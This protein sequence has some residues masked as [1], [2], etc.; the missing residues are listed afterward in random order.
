MTS[1]VGEYLRKTREERKLSLEQ[2]AAVTRVRLSY[3]IAIENDEQNDLPSVVQARGF[4]RLY[5]SFLNIPVQP[6]LDGWKSGHF[7]PE[8]LESANSQPT[9]APVPLNEITNPAIARPETEV[10]PAPPSPSPQEPRPSEI[11][12]PAVEA[13]E[14]QEWRKIFQ[15]I[16]STL[17]ERREKLSLSVGDI[18]RFTRLKGYYIQ[19]LEDGRVEDLPSMVQGRGMLS[20]Y[21][22]F[23]DLDSEGLM[24]RFADALQARRIQLATP[25]AAA[26]EKRP[27]TPLAKKAK[28][29]AGGWRRFLTLDMVLGGGLF[30]LLIGF[31]LW[32]TTRVINLQRQDTQPTLASISDILM[33]PN[34]DLSTATPDLTVSPTPRAAAA[35]TQPAVLPIENTAEAT[36]MVVPT[37]GSAPISVYIVATQRV[38]MRITVDT[39]IAF[40]GRTVPGVAYPFTGRESIQLLTGNGAALQVIYNENNL[41]TLGTTGEVV[42]ITFTREGT[43]VPTAIPTMTPTPTQTPTPTRQPTL[44]QITPSITPYIP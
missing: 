37:L 3:L 21:A 11:I 32:G 31:V 18:E 19:A 16:G 9:V 20:N 4:L 33:T 43:I 23:L 25:A 7:D 38:W 5:A 12:E 35:I 24:L 8:S 41:G 22:E 14:V 1:T 30:I 29:Q 15:E 42:N 36:L 44:P 13:Y 2:A 28:Q 10:L 34:P 17:R 6:L 40:E 26:S 39:T 27:S